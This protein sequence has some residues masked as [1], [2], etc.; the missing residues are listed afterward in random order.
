MK[1]NM[2]LKLCRA[3]NNGNQHNPSLIVIQPSY[4][5]L[6]VLHLLLNNGFIRGFFVEKRNNLKLVSVLLKYVNG[7]KLFKFVCVRQQK[8]KSIF[9]FRII[10]AKS[11][12]YV[13]ANLCKEVSKDVNLIKIVPA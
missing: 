10:S 9:H 8:H 11:G 3:L 5:C 7:K 2:L 13:N 12:L 1:K 6:K 4:F